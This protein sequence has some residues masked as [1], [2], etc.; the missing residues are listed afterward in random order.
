M[1][2]A[3][4]QDI[5]TSR[6]VGWLV[7]TLGSALL[8]GLGVAFVGGALAALSGEPG[9]GLPLASMGGTLAFALRLVGANPPMPD[10]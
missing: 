10:E 2:G 9:L 1:N 7:N 5:H 3:H 6:L 4:L 8:W